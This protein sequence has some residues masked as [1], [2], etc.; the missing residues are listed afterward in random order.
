[1][2]YSL[3]AWY[4]SGGLQLE[5]KK[6]QN[7]AGLELKE[8]ICCPTTLQSRNAALAWARA[9]IVQDVLFDL[10]FLYFIWIL[11]CFFSSWNFVTYSL[12]LKTV[13]LV[14][15]KIETRAIRH[16]RRSS[17]THKLKFCEMLPFQFHWNLKVLHFHLTY[18][19]M[20]TLFWEEYIFSALFFSVISL[21]TANSK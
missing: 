14:I 17:Q 3:L 10:F 1:M 2:E 13:Q 20:N 19:K 4:N 21:T 12:Q 5:K 18:I 8:D 7:D 9:L 6:R 16:S 15:V 11:I